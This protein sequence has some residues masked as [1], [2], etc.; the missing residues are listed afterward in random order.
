MNAKKKMGWGV[1]LA[2]AGV[3]TAGSAQA[4][5]PAY[6]NINVTITANVSV[7]VNGTDSSTTTVSWN[8]A[9][10]NDKLVPVG[11]ASATVRNDSGGVTEKWKL[12]TNPYSLSSVAGSTWSL[13]G[14]TAA[15]GADEF[16]VQAVFG[17]SGTASCPSGAAADWDAPFAPPLTASPVVYTSSVFADTNLDNGGTPLPD[18]AGGG[19]DGRMHAGSR[20]ALCWRVITPNSTS[21]AQT[22]NIQIVV[23]AVVP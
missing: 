10:P 11:L 1:V 14:S 3:M 9:T 4:A 16:A 5:N 22:Q 12:S 13:A 8:A 2:L 21:T 20:R 15:V 18:I 17:S 19:A 6:L 7:S 23:T